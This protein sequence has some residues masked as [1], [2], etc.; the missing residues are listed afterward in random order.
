MPNARRAHAGFGEPVVEPRGGAVAQVGAECLMNGAEHLQEHKDR[1]RKG[2]RSGQRMAM[3]HRAHQHA[4]G[5]RERRR[6]DAAQQQHRPPGR[7]QTR[8]RLG[9]HGEELPFLARRQRLQHDRILREDGG[10]ETL[11]L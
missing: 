9:Q 8:I 10:P 7:G 1:A 4:H 11:T 6:Q 3:L 5:N 2:E